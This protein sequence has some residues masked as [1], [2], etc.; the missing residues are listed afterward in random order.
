MISISDW[1][2]KLFDILS[3][4]LN[5]SDNSSEEEYIPL[6]LHVVTFSIVFMGIDIVFSLLTNIL[7]MLT[8]INAPSLRTPPN[9]HL[10][11]IGMNNVILCLCMILSLVSVG[12]KR[13]DLV[14]V[15]SVTGFQLFIVS[16]CSL[17]YLCAFTSICIYR[18][19]TIKR[20]SLCLRMRKRM[21]TRSILCGW[22]ASVLLSVVFCLSFMPN[23]D[24]ACDTWNPFQRE[25]RVCDSRKRLTSEQL[26]ILII[27]VGSYVAG[28]FI[29]FSSYYNICKSLNLTGTFRK[30]RV[31]PWN[32]NSSMSSEAG[33]DTLDQTQQM[34]GDSDFVKPYTI[35]SGKSDD[36]IVHYQ[37]SEHTLTFEDIFALENP[38]LAAKLKQNNSQKKPLKPTLSNTSTQ[39][40]KSKICTFTDISPV[41]NL[42]RIQNIKNAS[43]LRNQSLRRDRVSLSSATKNSFIMF[44]A[45]L[46]CSFPLLILCIPGVLDFMSTDAR[47]NTIIMCRLLFYINACFYPMWYLLFSKRVRQCLFRLLENILIRLQVRR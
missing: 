32:R 24:R 4:M 33:P 41:A 47:I 12:T 13:E 45:Y 15:Q 40:T 14:Y 27:Y 22:I 20:P 28:L 17:Q 29:I 6:S 9:N 42:Q 35:S 1:K 44:I 8:I 36:I 23:N 37:R 34:N 11:N 18:K 19:T 43:A 16:N 38:I 2:W 26:V 5:S 10:L 7:L 39:S 46:V 21:V 30:S 31:S 25:F 3:K